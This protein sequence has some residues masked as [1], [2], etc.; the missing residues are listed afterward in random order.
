M[1]YVMS[2]TGEDHR[3]IAEWLDSGQDYNQGVALFARLGKN[4]ILK[5]LFPGQEARYRRKLTY[6]LSKLVGKPLHPIPMVVE[7]N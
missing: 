5:K 6:E 3:K 1:K 4:Q 2:L 7:R